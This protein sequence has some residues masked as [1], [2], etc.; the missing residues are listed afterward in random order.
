MQIEKSIKDIN[1]MRSHL[2][3]SPGYRGKLRYEGPKGFYPGS[4]SL[5]NRSFSYNDKIMNVI[6]YVKLNLWNLKD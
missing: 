4:Q 2:W 6:H 3:L 1:I 5:N